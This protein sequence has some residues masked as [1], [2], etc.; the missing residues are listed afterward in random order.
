VQAL[1]E[2]YTDEEHMD[3][4]DVSDGEEIYP[5]GTGPEQHTLPMTTEQVDS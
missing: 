5:D 1:D 2:E 4:D 3:V